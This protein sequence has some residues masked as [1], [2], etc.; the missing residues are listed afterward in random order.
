MSFMTKL[1]VASL[2]A[3]GGAALGYKY[4]RDKKDEED[5]EDQD[6]KSNSNR[7]GSRGRRRASTSGGERDGESGSETEDT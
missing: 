1:L 4:G 3:G 5:E 6:G 2:L 7:T